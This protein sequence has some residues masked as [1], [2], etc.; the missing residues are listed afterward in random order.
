MPFRANEWVA[1]SV[2]NVCTNKWRAIS[3]R[4]RRTTGWRA[5]SARHVVM[6]MTS[7]QARLRGEMRVDK[8]LRGRLK[9]NWYHITVS[10]IMN[11][12]GKQGQNLNNTYKW[13][14]SKVYEVFQMPLCSLVLLCWEESAHQHLNRKIYVQ[15]PWHKC[16]YFPNGRCRWYFRLLPVQMVWLIHN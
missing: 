2:K 10:W 6:D 11:P 3:A 14:C 9:N 12:V 8:G 16:P 15:T 5:I 7:R 13:G 1:I 4:H